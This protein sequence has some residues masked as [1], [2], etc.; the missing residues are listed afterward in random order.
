MIYPTVERRTRRSDQPGLALQY[1]IEHA[2][3]KASLKALVLADDEG[4][5]VAVAGDPSICA[6]LAA[7]APWAG[8][9]PGRTLPSA[10]EGAGLAVRSLF[11]RGASL[12]LAALGDAAGC[13]AAL[14]G[15]LAGV[16]RILAGG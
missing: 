8:P 9:P 2:L 14:A 13:D 16:E 11:A 5:P 15:S 1:Q 10:L 7:V 12:H 3:R 6:E 4:L